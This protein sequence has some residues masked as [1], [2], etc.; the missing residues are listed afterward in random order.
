MKWQVLR[1][2]VF[3]NLCKN[4]LLEF[5]TALQYFTRIP[6]PKWTEELYH[7]TILNKSRTYFPLMGWIVGGIGYLVYYLCIKIF[8]LSLSVAFSILATI[9]ITGAFHEDGF[10]DTCDAFGGGT[11]SQ[12]ILS[13]LKDSRIGT[14][15]TIGLVFILGIKYLIL[16]ELNQM[17]P[18]HFL[19]IYVYSHS[20]SRFFSSLTANKIPYARMDLKSKAKPIAQTQLN[21][22]RMSFGFVIAV[23]PSFLAENYYLFIPSTIPAWITQYKAQNYFLKRIGGYTG[24]CL[25]AIQQLTEVV[26]YLSFFVVIQF[27]L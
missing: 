22:I 4:I 8:P 15:G 21:L 17:S 10:A 1:K 24:D 12:Q 3:L 27:F 26:I 5:F 6:V 20:M 11:N 25:G 16:F 13:I 2:L 19:A 7:P 14:Y 9:L 23:L 18:K